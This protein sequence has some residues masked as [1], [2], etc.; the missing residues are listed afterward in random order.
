MS[1]ERTKNINWLELTWNDDDNDSHKESLGEDL[2]TRVRLLPEKPEGWTFKELSKE[3][4][5]LENEYVSTIEW[6]EVS[7]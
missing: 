3:V 1:V 2:P 5:E 4:D 7:E 6:W